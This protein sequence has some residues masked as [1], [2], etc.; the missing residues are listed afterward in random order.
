VYIEIFVYTG[1]YIVNCDKMAKNI[2]ML[3]PNLS[4]CQCL[5][6]FIELGYMHPQ[7]IKY[8]YTH[9]TQQFFY[10]PL[11]AWALGR[12]TPAL[13]LGTALILGKG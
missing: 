3:Q 11:P 13:C 8:F 4:S 9:P 7:K 12:R 2:N 5:G 1:V 10:D 6:P